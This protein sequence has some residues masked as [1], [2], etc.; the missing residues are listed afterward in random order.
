[1]VDVLIVDDEERTRAG[2]AH[3]IDW[4]SH[5]L[6]VSG[7][8]AGAYEA[9]ERI[10][11]S[12]PAILVLDIKMPHMDGLELLHIVKAR[13]PSVRVI[14]I[15]GYDD[16]EFA[17]RAV[18]DNAFCYILKP[19]DEN[20]L[21][22]RA[23]EAKAEFQEEQ[24][25]LQ[26]DRELRR[27]FEACTPLA[28]SALLYR[29][30]SEGELQIPVELTSTHVLGMDLQGP[31][32]AVVLVETED[33]A[34]EADEGYDDR[35]YRRYAVMRKAETLFRRAGECY[36][37]DT[38]SALGFL[39]SGTHEGLCTLSGAARELTEWANHEAGFSCTVGIGDQVASL[40]GLPESYAG[41]HK[42][43][44]LRALT[45][46]NAVIGPSRLTGAPAD[47]ESVSAVQRSDVL[48]R[49]S[50]RRFVGAVR[51]GNDERVERTCQALAESIPAD[52]FGA[53]GTRRQLL[54][55]V[56]LMVLRVQVA[57]DL[58][59]LVLEEGGTDLIQQVY[60]ASGPQDLARC[61][62]TCLARIQD[63]WRARQARHNSHL[64]R[65]VVEYLQQNVCAGISLTAAADYVHVHPNYLSTIFR[66]EMGKTFIEYEIELK[67]GQAR[68]I[69]E[70]TTLRIYE[71]AERLGY[72]DANHFTKV[73]KKEVG[74]SPREYREL[75]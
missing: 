13:Y 25:R 55:R 3:S 9:L 37:F 46:R 73:F 71:I 15:S 45:G 56:V 20:E 63:A 64:V 67:M 53:P 47:A 8:A 62:S 34:A 54:T 43:M 49:R 24:S 29:M 69:L 72:R 57:L 52:L 4:A 11:H 75:L 40:G 42:A 41:A 18:H 21:V 1:M 2:L 22:Q 65:Q 35:I 60:G 59:D 30:V 38:P 17:R 39:V 48:L 50:E 26:E 68:R 51:A 58:D 10:E 12:V 7:T 74:V 32:Y 6:R 70:E 5:G 44:E 16:F 27:Q 14:L 33:L 66:S 28:R 31:T 36:G 61:L 19:I 23:L